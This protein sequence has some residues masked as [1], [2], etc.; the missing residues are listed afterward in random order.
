MVHPGN[1][2]MFR[3]KE[4]TYQATKRHGENLNACYSVKEASLKKV[5]YCM[6]PTIW[7]VGKNKILETVKGS[8]QWL[9]EVKG[10]WEI[11]SWCSEDFKGSENTVYNKVIMYICHYKFAKIH[12]MYNTK[13]KLM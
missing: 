13:S 1:E 2:I 5:M 4:M 6:I 7:H 9:P 10:N 12:R 11:N 8:F 3:G